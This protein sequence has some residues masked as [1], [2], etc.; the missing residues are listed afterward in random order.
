MSLGTPE[1]SA[2]QKLSIIIIF[3]CTVQNYCRERRGWGG[4]GRGG[5][6]GGSLDPSQYLNVHVTESKIF[7]LHW[8]IQYARVV[9]VSLLFIMQ[10]AAGHRHRNIGWCF[11]CKSDCELDDKYFL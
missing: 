11:K 10:L 6:R 7:D 1:N 4:W 2:I 9:V 5:G 3:R 8:E